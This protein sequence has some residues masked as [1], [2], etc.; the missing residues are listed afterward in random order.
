MGNFKDNKGKTRGKKDLNE[1]TFGKYLRYKRKKRK[2]RK[3][4]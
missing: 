1:S 2:K 3:Y 4:M